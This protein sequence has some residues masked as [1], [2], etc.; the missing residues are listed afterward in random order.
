[1]LYPE[2]KEEIASI[3]RKR[4]QS[5]PSIEEKRF[6]FKLFSG[7]SINLSYKE[8]VEKNYDEIENIIYNLEEDVSI[9]EVRD[10]LIRNK[11]SK[12]NQNK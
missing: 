1:M 2:L 4:M 7:L 5:L 11:K 6:Y 9:N 10:K 12:N 3:I 8:E